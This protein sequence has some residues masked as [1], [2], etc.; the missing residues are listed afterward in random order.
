M[1]RFVVP[2][3]T[4]FARGSHVNPASVFAP[5]FVEIRKTP[6]AYCKRQI[7]P[8]SN[9]FSETGFKVVARCLEIYIVNRDRWWMTWPCKKCVLLFVS[10]LIWERHYRDRTMGWIYRI[11]SNATYTV[12]YMQKLVK[13]LLL[14]T[15]IIGV[16]KLPSRFCVQR[17]TPGP[18][19]I[20]PSFFRISAKW[21]SFF[22][23][24]IHK[25][26]WVTMAMGLRCLRAPALTRDPAD[27]FIYLSLVINPPV[28]CIATWNKYSYVIC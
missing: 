11:I 5:S 16:A 9:E 1:Q 8:W 26:I 12:F 20:P 25:T 3:F 23:C 15:I 13:Y 22:D 2:T 14:T 18:S 21:F 6:W 7:F 10:I 24:I 27:G 17:V 4:W 19:F 28:Q